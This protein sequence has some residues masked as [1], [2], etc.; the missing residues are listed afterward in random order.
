MLSENMGAKTIALAQAVIAAMSSGKS[1]GFQA[2]VQLEV[3][4]TKTES[5]DVTKTAIG[6]NINTGGNF[7]IN[8]GK[9]AKIEGSNVSA[10]GDIEIDAEC[11]NN[12]WSKFKRQQFGDYKY[13]WNR[14]AEHINRIFI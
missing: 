1:Y 4:G 7:K 10:E 12:S 6:S 5:K 13:P 8:S 9:T 14:V 3:D 11:R 2:D